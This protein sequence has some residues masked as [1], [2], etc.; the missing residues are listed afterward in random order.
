MTVAHGALVLVGYPTTVSMG[1]HFSYDAQTL[2]HR[3]PPDFTE[4]P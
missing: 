2:K 3:T 1:F 4:Q